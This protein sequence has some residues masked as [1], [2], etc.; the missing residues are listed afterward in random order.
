MSETTSHR[1]DPVRGREVVIGVVLLALAAYSLWLGI[2]LDR[3][4]DCLQNYI[5]TNSATSAV[6]SD[7]VEAESQTTRKVILAF[8][9]REITTD[10]AFDRLGIQ[11]KGNLRKIDK[12][13]AD[14]PVVP[15]DP[16]RCT[17]APKE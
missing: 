9:N 3:Q 17:K 11:Y 8:V 15:F 14:N 10:A 16:D 12:K 13:R 2:R 5:E 4:R 7:Q 1:R 6:R